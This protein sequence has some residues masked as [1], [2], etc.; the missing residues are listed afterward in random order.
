MARMLIVLTQLSVILGLAILIIDINIVGNLFELYGMIVIGTFIF[1][2]IGFFLGSVA[3]TQEAIR[4]IVGLVTFPQV[5]LSGVFFPISSMPDLI[6]P[7]ASALPLS[8]VVTA[9]RDIANDGA[10]LLVI[11]HTTIGLILWM[12]LSFFLATKYFVWKEVAN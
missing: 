10:S 7:L 9:L 5:I 4:P 8:F 11:N 12:A 3:K 1:L 2:C 6:Q